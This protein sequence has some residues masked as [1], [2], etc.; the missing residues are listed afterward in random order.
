MDAEKA[1]AILE[2]HPDYRV[3]KRFKV[4]K[5]MYHGPTGLEIKRGLYVDTETTGKEPEKCDI[6]ELALVPFLFEPNGKL[7]G[8]RE[9][10]CMSFLNDPG[11]PLTDEIRKLTGIS[12]EDLAGKSLDMD[13]IN[14]M[15]VG[16]DLVVAHNAGYDRKV[17]ERTVPAFRNV[18]WACSQQDVPWRE[19]F[20]APAERLEILAHFLGGVFYGAHRAMID[21]MIGVHILATVE[22]SDGRTAFEYLY[23]ACQGETVRIWATGAPFETKDMLRDR[24][25][26]WNDGRDGRHKAWNKVVKPSELDTENQW[27]RVHCGAYPQVTTTESKDRYSIRDR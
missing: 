17:L 1:L 5:K 11:K 10:Q 7:L 6:L 13:V 27:L 24:G 21:C 19:V 2:K 23:E 16:V 9:E 12:D 20:G 26:R 18:A 14:L 15:L 22:D 25:Y 3:L 4:P 8:I